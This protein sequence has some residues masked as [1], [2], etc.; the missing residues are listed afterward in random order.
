[1]PDMRQSHPVLLSFLPDI[2]QD[3]PFF[4]LLPS[5]YSLNTVFCIPASFPFSFL[6]SQNP[7][8]KSFLP[9]LHY[10]V[11]SHKRNHLQ[12]KQEETGLQNFLNRQSFLIPP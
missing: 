5:V 3:K 11:S 12:E 10:T 9:H 7:P 4:P 6:H 1:M 8:R 2:S